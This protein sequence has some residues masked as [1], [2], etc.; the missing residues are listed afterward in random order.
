MLAFGIGLMEILILGVI[1][2]GLIAALVVALVV[3]LVT[4]RPDDGDD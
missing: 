3:R 4:R 2:G 1:G